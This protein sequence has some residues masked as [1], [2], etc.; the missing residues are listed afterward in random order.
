METKEGIVCIYTPAGKNRIEAYTSN[1]VLIHKPT[2]QGTSQCHSQNAI[3][4]PLADLQR[5]DLEGLA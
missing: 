1:T 5:F 3:L 4:S 2:V